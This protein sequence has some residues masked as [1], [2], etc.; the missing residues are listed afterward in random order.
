MTMRFT[1]IAERD[2]AYFKGD[3]DLLALHQEMRRADEAW[4]GAKAFDLGYDTVR[5]LCEEYIASAYKFQKARW[6][7]IRCRLSPSH[8]MR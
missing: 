1:C 4:L 7:R 8:L 6:G 3:K 5:G 2:L